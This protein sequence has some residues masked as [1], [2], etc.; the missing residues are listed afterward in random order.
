MGLGCL[1]A[2]MFRRLKGDGMGRRVAFNQPKGRGGPCALITSL[3]IL[4]PLE[5]EILTTKTYC[6]R[7]SNT[8]CRFILR[9]CV[10]KA[11]SLR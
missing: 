11:W 4:A 3:S 10:L 1:G 5:Y 8:S 9:T 6:P 7:V 2:W